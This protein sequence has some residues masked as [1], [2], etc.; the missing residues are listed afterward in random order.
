MW[1]APNAPKPIF[2]DSTI[3][4]QQL[5]QHITNYKSDYLST[6]EGQKHLA[7]AER[8]SDEVKEVFD[9]IW[10]KYQ[11]GQ[12]ITEDVLNRLLPHANTEFHRENDYR[13]STWPCITKDVRKWFEGAKW[14]TADQWPETVRLMLEAIHGINNDNLKPWN[15]FVG[16]PYRHGF[17]T[18]FISPILFCL[19]QKFPVI[20]SKVVKTYRYC[21]SQLGKPDDV[22]ASLADY[23]DNSKKVLA[24]YKKLQAFGI[25][26]LE[27]AD[28]FCHYMVTK[29]YGGGD[30]TQLTKKSKELKNAAAW[31]FVANPKIYELKTAFEENGVE[32]TGSRGG[33][34]QKIIREQLKVGDRIFGYQAGPVYA[35]QAELMVKTSPYK[36]ADGSWAV[37]LAP[38]KLFTKPVTLSTLKAHP[39]LSQ[40]K[41]VQQTQMSISGISADQLRVLESLL[42]EDTNE[43]APLVLESFVIENISST[44]DSICQ[45][46]SETQHDT[47][48]P[49]L[50]EKALADAFAFLGFETEHIGGPGKA[51]VLVQAVLGNDSYSAVV[52]AKTCQKG[53]T[54]SSPNYQPVN[55]HKEQNSADYALF[56]A[57]GF[58]GGN[59]IG[60]AEKQNVGLL[61]TETLIQLLRWHDHIP[62]TLY[63]LER[64]FKPV[65]YEEKLGEEF[66]R[67]HVQQDELMQLANEV[68][69]LIDGM[70]RKVDTSKPLSAQSLE[71][72][73]LFQAQ[74]S[75]SKSYAAQ[76]VTAILELLA[77]PVLG[78]LKKEPNGYVLAMP[79]ESAAGRVT[80]LGQIISAD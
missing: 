28:I 56:V 58:A 51:D 52:D 61:Q 41:F 71:V 37:D 22:N 6:A 76:D 68:I 29:K 73:F 17:G 77:N 38:V 48:K 25:N 32:W 50:F 20:N 69:Q 54:L 66:G 31:L 36:T 65:G 27:E 3:L 11:A 18:G 7:I 67:Q 14:K 21:M 78:I 49:D 70:Q 55:D 44:V 19:D 12:D 64:L 63:D 59:T 1:L 15:K 16:S 23:Q 40:I 8:E 24:L 35:I 39:L 79:I 80:V 47:K 72:L 10:S 5:Q 60:H 30:L 42:N 33:Y 62:F 45:T 53:K 34:A 46:L 75:G 13:I 74:Q 26:T 57:P 43:S 4:S 9:V 2:E